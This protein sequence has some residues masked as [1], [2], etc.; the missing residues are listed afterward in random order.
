ETLLGGLAEAEIVVTR[1]AAA[2]EPLFAAVPPVPVTGTA[3]GAWQH[4]AGAVPHHGQRARLQAR[5]RMLAG[6]PP[7]PGPAASAL[8][9]LSPADQRTVRQAWA[10]LHM[11]PPL[12]AGQLAAA[13]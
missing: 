6:P 13:F 4:W 5:L 2:G 3:A 11:L 9:G 12:T 7:L 10:L 1:P 8:A